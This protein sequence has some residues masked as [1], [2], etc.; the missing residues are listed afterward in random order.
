[1]LSFTPGILRLDQ[2]ANRY[3]LDIRIVWVSPDEAL[4]QSEGGEGEERKG[5][6]VALLSEL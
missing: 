3:L 4:E 6:G 1:L 5:E 2:I